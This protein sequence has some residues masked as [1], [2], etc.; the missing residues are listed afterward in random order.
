M[1]ERKGQY[2]ERQRALKIEMD[3]KL[4]MRI[5]SNFINKGK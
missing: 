4:K 2:Q 5:Q 1:D 3:E